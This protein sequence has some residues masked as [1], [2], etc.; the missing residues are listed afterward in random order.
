MKTEKVI[1]KCTVC[2][3]FEKIVD[4]AVNEHGYFTF[5][6]AYCPHCLSLMEQIINHHKDKK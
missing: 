5:P 3:Q 4:I 6:D 2:K 1:I